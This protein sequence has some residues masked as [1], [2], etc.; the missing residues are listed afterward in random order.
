MMPGAGR[1]MQA[2]RWGGSAWSPWKSH[3]FIYVNN[4]PMVFVDPY[5]LRAYSLSGVLKNYQNFL[6]GISEDAY[7]GY[8]Y[9]ANNMG[10]VAIGAGVIA[11][12]AVAWPAAAT[13][14]IVGASFISVGAAV[15]ESIE[16][17][18]KGKDNSKAI[19][20]A[21][22]RLASFYLVAK[23][24]KVAVEKIGNALRETAGKVKKLVK[25]IKSGD[26]VAEA[27]TNVV[28]QLGVSVGDKFEIGQKFGRLGTV[29]EPTGGKI[30]GYT[31]H[32]LNQ[33][34]TRAVKSTDVLNTVRNPLVKLQQ[35]NGKM[36]YLSETA[37]VVLNKAGEAVT[38]Y[39][40]AN[41]DSTI[42]NLLGY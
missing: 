32:A 9:A 40:K 24:A 3:P 16:L 11:G 33:K 31:R 41:F 27:G 14:T 10:E 15:K 1:F 2:D 8:V 20:K 35:S 26:N 42:L 38:I 34:I 22:G 6:T 23:N 13:G 18:L 5:G 4:N 19:G 12:L 28:K 29:V 17:A 7:D 37:A 25:S 30:L 39:G 36:L 21:V